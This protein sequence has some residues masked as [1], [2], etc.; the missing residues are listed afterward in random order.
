MATAYGPPNSAD[1][2][3]HPVLRPSTGLATIKLMMAS[4]VALSSMCLAAVMLQ[5]VMLPTFDRG[6]PEPS[7]EALPAAPQMPPPSP[8]PQLSDEDLQEAFLELVKR[9]ASI[10]TPL[11]TS[12]WRPYVRKEGKGLPKRSSVNQTQLIFVAGAEGTGH[13]FITALMMR[14]PALMPMTLVQEQA[15]Q[16]LWWKKG[17]ETARGHRSHHSPAA[18]RRARAERTPVTK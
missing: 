12:F 14:L 5:H 8:T 9:R 7:G 15:F 10:Q 4:I 17:E 11:D 6:N 3:I 16:A 1:Q 18:R 2:A 13:H